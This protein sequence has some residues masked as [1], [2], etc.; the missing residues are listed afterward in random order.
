[1]RRAAATLTWPEEST[2]NRL[3]QQVRVA[4]RDEAEGT[5]AQRAAIDWLESL[6]QQ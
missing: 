5:S 6:P 1:M 3:Q 4:G 2:T